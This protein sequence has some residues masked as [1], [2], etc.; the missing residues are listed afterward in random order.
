MIASACF[1]RIFHFG[2]MRV[3]WARR[4]AK[5]V[6]KIS[7]PPILSTFRIDAGTCDGAGPGWL[8]LPPHTELDDA[9]VAWA[10]RRIDLLPS[11]MC[12]PEA[13]GFA[14]PAEDLPA[15]R[16]LVPPLILP[17][18]VTGLWCFLRPR[19]PSSRTCPAGLNRFARCDSFGHP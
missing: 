7:L 9:V 4:L 15:E 17:T 12:W 10:I 3:N 2:R 13:S 18:S 8:A 11:T 1:A 5:A 6:L 19:L 16:A 14:W